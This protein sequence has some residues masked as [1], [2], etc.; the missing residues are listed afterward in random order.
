VL[1]APSRAAEGDATMKAIVRRDYGTSEVLRLEDL[2]KPVPADNQV[3]LKVRAA[4]TNPLD[5][6]FMR[7]TPYLLR[8]QAGLSA[9]QDIRLGQ[10]VAGEVEAVG[11]AVT[12]FKP[13]DEVYGAGGG[14]FA[15]YVRTNEMNLVAKPAEI[16]FEQAAAVP[17]AGVTA[18]QGLRDHGQ[19]KAGQKV[20]INGAS[21]GVGTF[22]VQIAKVLGAEVTAVCSGRN[23]E[24]VKSLGADHV[25]DYTKDDF[26][27]ASETYDIVLDNV[28]NRSPGE[29]RRVM[30][31]SGRYVG[32][33]GGGPEDGKWVG[34]LWSLV[35]VFFYDLFT[36]Q[37][38]TFFLAEIKPAD[39]ATLNEMMSAGKL[40]PVIDQVFPLAQT[41]D[42]LAY[43]EKG[44][45]RGKVV[46]SVSTEE[47]Q[48]P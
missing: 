36:D 27:A 17:I 42:A 20:L 7:G 10:D 21:G 12:L 22:A 40:T 38:F 45:A 48:L 1:A 24:L 6:H 29:I 11:R 19:L 41:A 15:E 16:T 2:P 9:P 39:L 37:S 30:T 43:L 31:P 35:K 47:E 46:I 34:P 28:G 23:V 8:L 14:A 44:R 32:I 26:T 5:W 33:G 3:L 25:I 4:A 13:G 18:L